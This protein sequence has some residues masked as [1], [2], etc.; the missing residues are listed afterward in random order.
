MNLK[1]TLNNNIQTIGLNFLN[2]STSF[3]YCRPSSIFFAALFPAAA[4]ASFTALAFDEAKAEAAFA[5]L[6]ADAEADLAAEVAFA[7]NELEL[8]LALSAK[9]LALELAFAAA[10]FAAFVKD[11]NINY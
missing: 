2:I 11:F 10:L 8:L 1:N 3:I 5:L 9:D 6:D 7:A 4:V